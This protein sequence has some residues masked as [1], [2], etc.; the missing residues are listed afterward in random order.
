MKPLIILAWVASGLWSAG[1]SL[2]DHRTEFCSNYLD[3]YHARE[4]QIIGIVGG[5]AFGPMWGAITLAT[6]GYSGW[7]LSGQRTTDCG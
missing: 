3:P 1:V 6:H 5:V 7:T 2:A 4:G